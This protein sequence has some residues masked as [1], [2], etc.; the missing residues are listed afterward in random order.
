MYSVG[1]LFSGCGGTDL[2]FELAGF[3]TKWFCEID[4]WCNKILEK[5]F[6]DIPNLGDINEIKEVE[7]L[8]DYSL[9]IKM[10][11]EGN[12]IQEVADYFSVTRQSM[13][14]SLQIRNV[15]FRS[16]LKFGEENHFYRGGIIKDEYVSNLTEEAIERGKLLRPDNCEICNKS[17][18]FKNNRTAIQAHHCDYNKPLEVMWL[19]QK[20]HHNWHKENKAVAKTEVMPNEV[21]QVDV[22]IGGFP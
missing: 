1:S 8:K 17:Y 2:G 19:C 9:A 3:E 16:N 22:L 18:K 15:K 10:Y 5:N 13:W 7:K 20:C 11:Q 21:P 6:P 14:K 12:S 4:K